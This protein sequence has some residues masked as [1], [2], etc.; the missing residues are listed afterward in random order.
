MKVLVTGG[1]GFLG[2]RLIESMLRVKIEVVG[3]D[4]LDEQRHA[5]SQRARLAALEQNERFRFVQGD[6]TDFDGLSACM[7]DA[8]PDAVVHL[9]SKKDLE[10]ADS[11]AQQC[12]YLYS[13]GM[14]NVVKACLI[15][16]V[17]HLVFGSSSH[18]YGG[19]RVFPFKESD[20]CEEPLSVLGAA[21]RSA[22]LIARSMVA[23]TKLTVTILRIFSLYGPGQDA[24]NFLPA[25][26]RA[27]EL[28]EPLPL[29][30][31]GTASRDMLHVDDAVLALMSG[32][33]RPDGFR[34]FNLGSG[35]TTTLA[36]V[37]ELVSWIAGKTYRTKN[38]PP[39]PG[40]MPHTF[41]DIQ[42]IEKAMGF[43]T[44]VDWEDGV[45]AYMRWHADRPEIFRSV[46]GD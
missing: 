35:K 9:A 32:L 10:W 25:L 46:R 27:T 14:A 39:R 43:H 18:V 38:L 6:V 28:D 8:R 36:Q 13:V 21:L 7:R 24:T 16:K 45:R 44:S 20:P 30:G 37:A 12:L 4:V 41:A 2:S 17:A 29:L 11:Q 15:A 22:E 33:N 26:A 1:A 40:E 42:K 31:D 3:Y 19:S 23:G 34:I 5:G